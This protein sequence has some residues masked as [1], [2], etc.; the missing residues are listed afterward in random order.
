M[1][2]IGLAA[3]SAQQRSM[4]SCARRCISG[5]PRC[6]EAKSSC[7][8]R[9]ATAHRRGRTA[10]EADQHRGTA[11]HDETCADRNVG[12]LDVRPPNIA[13]AAGDHD[14]LVIAAHDQSGRRQAAA[15]TCGSSQQMLGRPNSLLNAAAP[16]GPSSMISSA[17]AIRSGRPID[18]SQGCTKSGNAQMR[19]G[20]AGQAGFGLGAAAGGAF[21]AD[22]AARTGR[23]ARE[24]RDR[25]RM[26]V[27][28][29]FHQDVDR[30]QP[31]NGKR[32]SAGSGKKRLAVVPSI[33]AALSR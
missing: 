30:L 8:T 22:L 20:K 26:V 18:L 28:F 31:V 29:D 9:D 6:T 2:R 14:R 17:E 16:I 23:G 27:R 15:R 12:F 24:R 1:S 21:V 11:Q 13:E 7:G 19:D 3:P 25:R 32:P 10:A 33:T 4:T 5:L